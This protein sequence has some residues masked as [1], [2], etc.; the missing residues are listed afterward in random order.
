[1]VSSLPVLLMHWYMAQKVDPKFN[2]HV[3]RGQCFKKPS[4]FLS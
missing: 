4:S 1:M 2:L 3:H